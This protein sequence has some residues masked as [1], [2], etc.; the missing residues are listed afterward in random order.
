MSAHDQAYFFQGLEQLGHALRQWKQDKQANDIVNT[1]RPPRAAAVDPNADV[2]DGYT[3]AGT[4]PFTGG[5]FGAQLQ[6]KLQDDEVNRRYKQALIEKAL[7]EPTKTSRPS[8]VGEDGLTPYQREQLGISRARENRLTTHPRGSSE[9]DKLVRDLAA[10]G[11]SPD[12]IPDP[13][14]VMKNGVTVVNAD[15][16]G[17][18]NGDHWQFPSKS[19]LPVTIKKTDAIGFVNRALKLRPGFSGAGS[20]KDKLGTSAQ[21]SLEPDLPQAQKPLDPNTAK[22][23][24]S[25]AGGDKEKA[26]ELARQRGY[27]F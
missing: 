21:S 9:G 17:D 23:I 15:G 13:Q 18:P 26:R 16:Q 22:A 2:A 1:L 27:S 19:G 24:L 25:E 20:Y 6:N 14:E 8:L 7:R 12:D 11:L 3:A 5:V 4:K 10:K